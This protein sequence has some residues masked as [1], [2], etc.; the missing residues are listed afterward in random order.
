MKLLLIQHDKKFLDQMIPKLIPL[1]IELYTAETR[2]QVEQ[3][4]KKRD[5]NSLFFNI[6]P[7]N[8]H[9]VDFIAELKNNIHNENL[10]I[11]VYLPH[12]NHKCL[13]K[14]YQYGITA[15][16]YHSSIP[17]HLITQMLSIIRYLEQE[18]ERRGH[19]RIN[20]PEEENIT[21]NFKYKNKQIK[22]TVY[23]LSPVALSFDAE[24]SDILNETGKKEII[25][26]I[27]L[28][29]ED[30]S[31]NIDAIVVRSEETVA[32]MYVNIQEEFLNKLCTY[33]FKKLNNK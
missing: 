4:I 21:I 12:N 19:V 24:N 30:Q 9:W 28:K 15:F 26:N 32:L 31:M 18:G 11:A 17:D 5:N 29:I 16:I 27:E 10:K 3:W 7:E 2:E 22:G 8:T 25:K 13:R 23:A 14:L 20:I 33:I 1:G 6:T